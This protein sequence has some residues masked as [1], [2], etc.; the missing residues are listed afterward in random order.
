MGVGKQ[1]ATATCTAYRAIVEKTGAVVP[2]EMVVARVGWLTGLTQA[3][4]AAVIAERWTE[5]ALD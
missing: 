2:T 4:A 5:K 1:I 3:L